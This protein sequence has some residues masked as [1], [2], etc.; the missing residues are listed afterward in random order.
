[1][2]YQTYRK[3]KH[4]PDI[5]DRIKYTANLTVP[6]NMVGPQTL[7]GLFGVDRIL[8]A[9]AIRNTAV[10]NATDAYGFFHGKNALLM[11]VSPRPSLLE[12]TAGYTFAWKGVSDGLGSQVGI[13]RFRMNHLR[14]ERIEAQM[15]WDNKLVAANLGYFFSSA[16]A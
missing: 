7:A 9:K 1:M 13:T 11:Y 16:V 4:H 8:V 10:E 12:A 15:A 3:L 5:L 14:A 6:A 2:G